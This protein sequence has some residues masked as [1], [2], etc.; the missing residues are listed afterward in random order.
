[1][2]FE[3]DG[4]AVFASTGSVAFDAAKPG[5][6]FVHGAGMDHSV[7]VMS[8]RYFARH[9]FAVLAPD[10]PAHGRSGGAALTSVNAMAHWL[11]AVLDVLGMQQTAVVGH[12]MGSLVAHSFARLHPKRCR[13]LALLGT[14]APM[15]VTESLLNAAQD[16]DHA[17]IDMANGWSH[18]AQGKLGAAAV[19]WGYASRLTTNAAVALTANIRAKSAV[20]NSAL[21]PC[22]CRPAL[23]TNPVSD[24]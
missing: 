14:S 10:L 12:S 15:P 8:A 1:M 2:K 22:I 3:V 16:N 24:P 20:E 21:L 13:A 9:G 19:R 18:S 5:V 6:L 11:V 4:V 23:F 7:W 17:A